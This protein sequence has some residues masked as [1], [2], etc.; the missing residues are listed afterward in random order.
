MPPRSRDKGSR[1][2]LGPFAT[3]AAARQEYEAIMADG[4]GMADLCVE[5]DPAVI[6]QGPV[7]GR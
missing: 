4:I 5:E 3:E 2:W 7:D 6:N 1:R